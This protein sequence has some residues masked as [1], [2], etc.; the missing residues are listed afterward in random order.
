MTLNRSHNSSVTGVVYMTGFSNTGTTGVMCAYATYGNGRVVAL[1]D[2]SPADD[3]TGDTGDNLYDGWIEDADGNHERLI[4][5]ATIWLAGASSGNADL[6]EEKEKVIVTV[7]DHS[8]ELLIKSDEIRSD[9]QISIFDITGREIVQCMSVVSNE[10]CIINL[11]G[12]GVYLYKISRNKGR[13]LT[14]K[15]IL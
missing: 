4:M 15:F 7:S 1:G 12:R 11:P 2:S 13:E 9:Y 5:N 3:G 10:S 6:K 14:G 8:A